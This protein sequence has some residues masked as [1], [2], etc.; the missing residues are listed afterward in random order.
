MR[1]LDFKTKGT[2]SKAIHLEIDDDGVVKNV[3]FDGGCAGNTSGLSKLAIGRPA[4]EI[5]NILRGTKCGIKSTSCPDQLAKAID[6][7]L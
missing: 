1:T 4:K 2:C 3:K 5:A 7:L 6:E